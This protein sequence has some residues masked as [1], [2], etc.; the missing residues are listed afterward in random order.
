LDRNFGRY[1]SPPPPPTTNDEITAANNGL[2]FDLFRV[3]KFPRRWIVQRTS[4]LVLADAY[5]SVSERE[6][7]VGDQVVFC[8]CN[9]NLT[10]VS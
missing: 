2:V 8:V 9:V 5:R 3:V 1:C 7:G 6:I 10:A 4:G